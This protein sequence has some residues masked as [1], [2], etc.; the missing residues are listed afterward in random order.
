MINKNYTKLELNKILSL[1]SEQAVSDACKEKIAQIAPLSDAVRIREDL[2]KT[3]DAFRLSARLGTPRFSNIKDPGESLKRAAQGGSLSL[4]E[5]LDI[6]SVLREINI[7]IHWNNQ[8]KEDNALSYLFSRLIPNKD[9]LERIDTAIISDDEIA[10]SASPELARIRQSLTKQSQLIRERLDK[11]IRTS[12]T[13]KFLQE[14]I[15]TQ[16]DGRFVIPVKVEHKN[17]IPGLVHDTSGS[18]AT[19]F[20]EPMGVVEANNEIRVLKSREKD[21]IER[22]IAELSAL[23]GGFADELSH[24]FT[25]SIK[26]ELCFSKANFGAKM[27][28]TIPQITEEAVLELHKARHPLINPDTVVPISLE[29]G[30]GE[31]KHGVPVLVV[32]GPNTGGKT[33]AIKTAGLLTLMSRCGLMIPAAD[34]SKIGIPGNVYADIGDEQSI[35]QSLSTFSSHMNNIVSILS[36]ARKGDLVLLDELGSGT[37]PSEGGALAVAILDCLKERGCLVIATTHYQE[38]KIYAIETEGVENA[39]CEFDIATL[40]P[41]YRLIT[42]APGKSNALAIAKRLGLGDD[43]IERAKTLVSSENKRFDDIIRSLEDSRVEIEALKAQIEQNERDSREMTH[44]LEDE[45][46]KLKA[47]REKE[48]ANARQRSLSII[49]SV[50][51][52]ADSI[53]DELEELKRDRDKSDFSERVRGMRRQVNSALNKLHDEANPIESGGV[54]RGEASSAYVLPR[55]LKQYD[56]VLLADSG[57]KGSVISLPDSKGNCTVQIGIVKTKTNLSNLRLVKEEQVTLNGQSINKKNI[58]VSKAAHTSSGRSITECDIRGMSSDEGIAA[59]DSFIDSSLMNNI[60]GVTVIHGKGTGI[61][62][63]AVHGFLRSNRLVKDYR[64]GKYGEGEDGVT[65]V[66]LKS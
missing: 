27:K 64:L 55:P 37:D 23:C 51:Q 62:R 36:T 44:K 10:D 25:V 28:G 17:E 19:L 20:V 43:V 16:R 7:L 31:G 34:G 57:K 65:I 40:R 30:V 13:K 63:Q 41:T 52:S 45:R 22:I 29:I 8:Y 1:L 48:M 42:G 2:A 6:A 66:N 9:L 11:L 32:T 33:V 47:F 35:E 15:V 26:V 46:E 12:E 49:E 3:A 4:R 54:H 21:E 50:R 24:G 61:L 39:S 56:T 5:L 14:S 53:L 60:C 18:G 59:V 38:V 58:T